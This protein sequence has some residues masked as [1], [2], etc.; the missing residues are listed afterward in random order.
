MVHAGRV[1]NREIKL[2]RLTNPSPQIGVIAEIIQRERMNQ[3]AEPRAGQFSFDGGKQS[4]VKVNFELR[5]DVRSSLVIP[6]LSDKPQFGKRII[7]TRRSQLIAQ[8]RRYGALVRG[9]VDVSMIWRVAH[10]VCYG[11][12]SAVNHGQPRTRRSRPG[13]RDQLN[14]PP[15]SA[16]AFSK[17]ATSKPYL[18]R[19]AAILS[20]PT[21]SAQ[22][23]G[24]PV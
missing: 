23:I 21:V 11:K 1:K 7:G 19:L 15:C 17:G 14:L 22:N 24:P 9:I 12:P 20:K 5:G 6:Q 8:V 10:F 16:F 3:N 2:D 4:F 13:G 18:V